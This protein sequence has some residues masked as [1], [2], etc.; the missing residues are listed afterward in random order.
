MEIDIEQARTLFRALGIAHDVCKR[1]GEKI[2]SDADVSGYLREA[3]A[4]KYNKDTEAFTKLQIELAQAYP[5]I[6]EGP[7]VR[8]S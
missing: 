4:E 8:P 6:T 1:E 3:A 7:A 2:W 5:E